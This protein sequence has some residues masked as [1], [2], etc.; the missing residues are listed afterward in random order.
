MKSLKEAKNVTFDKIKQIQEQICEYNKELD[1]YR[2]IRN[3]QQQDYQ[4]IQ[5]LKS[6][7][8]IIERKIRDLENERCSIEKI[9]E[10]SIKEIKVLL[11]SKE[12]EIY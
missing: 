4:Q 10:S 12:F 11:Y 5:G 2:S 1:K 6:K 7:I 3:K 8:S 9:K